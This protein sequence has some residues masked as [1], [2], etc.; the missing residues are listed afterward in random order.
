MNTLRSLS[1]SAVR[2]RRTAALAVVALLVTFLVS[3][4]GGGSDQRKEPLR[5]APGNTRG[6][7]ES[8]T[9]E[10]GGTNGNGT[11]D[12][13]NDDDS[14]S[15]APSVPGTSGTPGTTS[16]TNPGG[17]TE[18]RKVRA[19]AYFLHG[20][21]VSPVP[22]TV[23]PPSTAAEAIR[24]LLAGPNRYE[25]QHDR[26][27]AIPS[28][29]TLNSIAVRDHV[30]TVNLSGRYDDGGGS[31]SMKARLAQVVFTATRFPSIQKV[32]FEL[33]G[34]PVTSFGGEGVVLNGP[35]GRGYFEDLTP[36]VLVESPLIGETIHSP[37]RV[38]GSANTFEATL[39]LKIEDS[40][41]K[42]VANPYATATSGSGTRGTFDVTLPYRTATSGAG[43]LI[44]YYDSPEDGRPAGVDTIPLT[45][46]R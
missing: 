39:R 27:T 1:R 22:R 7:S 18:P 9:G 46:G 28:G 14:P 19:V 12:E 30:A 11:P 33:D 26:S 3:G 45:V 13:N 6:G 32:S 21:K 43:R 29:T 35:V 41:G 36:T 37:V 44:A 5:P 10:H 24:S 8:P 42:T 16:S 25:R 40:T 34:K 23:S 17:T 4:C 38:W 2:P 20:E 31:L 15:A